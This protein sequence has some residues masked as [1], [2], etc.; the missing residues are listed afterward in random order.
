MQY[1]S[2]LNIPIKNTFKKNPLGQIQF[3]IDMELWARSP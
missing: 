3:N 1:W 2:F